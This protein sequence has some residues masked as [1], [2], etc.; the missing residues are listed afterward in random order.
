MQGHS[1]NPLRVI[2]AAYDPHSGRMVVVRSGCELPQ[3][4]R[5]APLSADTT[6][7]G[8]CGMPHAV[9]LIQQ[10]RDASDRSR[11]IYTTHGGLSYDREGSLQHVTACR[12]CRV[13]GVLNRQIEWVGRVPDE[14]TSNTGANQ[15]TSI[16]PRLLSRT[17]RP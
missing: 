4:V 9:D 15:R 14:V 3:Y 11:P 10:G 8:K 7:G 5:L 2:E 1:T 13:L 6:V 17:R 16:T 12:N